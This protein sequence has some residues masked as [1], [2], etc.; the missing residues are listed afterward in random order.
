MTDG[1]RCKENYTDAL[2]GFGQF[3]YNYGFPKL[4]KIDL[5]KRGN[6]SRKKFF[7]TTLNIRDSLYTAFVYSCIPRGSEDALV[8]RRCSVCNTSVCNTDKWETMK[9]VL[10]ELSKKPQARV[11]E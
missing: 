1:R 11:C 2:L 3:S 4:N 5:H 8:N 9:Q 6:I 7:E 10:T